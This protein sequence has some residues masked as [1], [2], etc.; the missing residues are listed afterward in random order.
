MQVKVPTYRCQVPEQ[1]GHVKEEL[2]DQVTY[3]P[4]G[5]PGAVYR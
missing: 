1:M 5:L 3:T 2:R 4:F